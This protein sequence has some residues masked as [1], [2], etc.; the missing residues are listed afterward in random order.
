MTRLFRR[1]EIHSDALR[2]M[3]NIGSGHAATVL[4]QLTGLRVMIA[5]PEVC[6]APF[7]GLLGWLPGG[8]RSLVVLATRMLGDLSGDTYFLLPEAGA[9][10]LSN[11]LLGR[12]ID[13]QADLLQMEQSSLIEAGNIVASS[14]M[15]AL[16]RAVGGLVMPSV[17]TLELCQ[18]GEWH[19]THAASEYVLLVQTQFYFD[20]PTGGVADASSRAA[21]SL[22]GAFVFAPNAASFE[23]MR[24]NAD[25][26][27]PDP[28]GIMKSKAAFFR[29]GQSGSG[30]DML[31]DDE[32]V[33]YRAST[34]QPL[35]LAGVVPYI[36]AQRLSARDEPDSGGVLRKHTSHAVN[37]ASRASRAAAMSALTVRMTASGEM[38]GQWINP[39]STG[40]TT[41]ACGKSQATLYSATVMTDG[42]SRT[43]TSPGSPLTNTTV[44]SSSNC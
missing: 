28:A 27:A 26:T 20:G 10:A 36:L 23:Q 39:I 18:D 38:F 12:S 25:R 19:A 13:T 5:V 31:S 33:R 21:S 6:V 41:G 8:E 9:R 2:E 24:A 44:P 17:P 32:M 4:S 42:V 29:N 22:R 16:A 3:A 1:D 14:F 35:Y 37:L 40:R 7:D 43:I 11:L 15:N 30:R 34:W